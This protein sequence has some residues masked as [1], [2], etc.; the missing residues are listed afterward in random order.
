[1]VYF[2]INNNYHWFDV[3]QLIHQVYYKHNISLIQVPNSLEA[4]ISDQRIDNIFIF[5]KLPYFK[6]FFQRWPKQL[7]SYIVKCFKSF[8][9]ISKKLDFSKNDVLFVFTEEEILNLFII[10]QAKKKGV[11]IYLLED[12]FAS[13]TIYNMKSDPLSKRAKLTMWLFRVVFGLK[14]FYPFNVDGY[15]SIRL[16]KTYYSGICFYLPTKISIDLPV[17]QI[18]KQLPNQFSSNRNQSNI[19]FLTAPIYLFYTDFETYL[20]S[21]DEIFEELTRN[22]EIVYVKFHHGDIKTKKSIP[23][24]TRLKK[25]KNVTFIRNNRIIEELIDEY[26]TAYAISFFSSALKNL[27]FYGVEPVYIFHLVEYLKNFKRHD[28]MVQ[29]LNYLGYKF[30][31][32]IREIKPGY[33]S[34]LMKHVISNND[35]ISINELLNT[36]IS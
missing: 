9:S 8:R 23:I 26:N 6:S 19:L 36:Q 18:K 20:T 25:Y 32:S 33:Y 35:K 1:M 12:G 31:K 3:N 10:N 28:I 7:L 4:I 5:E 11:R 14:G 13:A 21:L 30:P 29:Y 15:Y 24:E 34:G 22:F 2:L 17:F 27:L 16:S